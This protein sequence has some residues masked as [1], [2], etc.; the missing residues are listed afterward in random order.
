M[1]L[2]AGLDPTKV[3]IYGQT[4]RFPRR[5]LDY[6]ELWDRSMAMTREM[7]A[8]K[9]NAEGYVWVSDIDMRMYYEKA[10]LLTDRPDWADEDDEGPW[11]EK[12]ECSQA[13]DWNVAVL[14][15][16]VACAPAQG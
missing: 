11:W 15:I 12:V 8:D 14:M 7:L 9:I 4:N 2:P 5:M 3:V 1:R 10:V 13:D 6:P 16:E